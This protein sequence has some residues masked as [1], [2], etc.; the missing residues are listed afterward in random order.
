MQAGWLFAMFGLIVLAVMSYYT[1][2]QISKCGHLTTRLS[3]K[4]ISPT[5]PEIGN[6]AFGKVGMIAA[7][8][9]IFVMTLGLVG[10]YFVFIGTSL[11]SI[12]W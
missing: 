3:P 11:S 8:F 5:Y 9:G 6:I 7:Y 4:D 2:V 1:L 10:S 12:L